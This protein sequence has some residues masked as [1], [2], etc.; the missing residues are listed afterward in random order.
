MIINEGESRTNDDLMDRIHISSIIFFLGGIITC[1]WTIT[2]IDSKEVTCVE[3]E[4]MDKAP[5]PTLLRA[6]N[7]S[8]NQK[9]SP[10]MTLKPCS[11]D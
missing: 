8:S 4:Y 2:T 5:P 1:S 3:H 7:R 10:K 11:E 6:L 9:Y